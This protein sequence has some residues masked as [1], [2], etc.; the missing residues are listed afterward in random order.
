MSDSEPV[1]S[2]VVLVIIS[3]MECKSVDGDPSAVR[4][5]AV[6]VRSMSNQKR[7]DGEQKGPNF[8]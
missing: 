4:F 6:V 7:D 1:V 8:P 5:D 2:Q 3:W